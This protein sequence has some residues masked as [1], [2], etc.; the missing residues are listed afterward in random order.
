M[1][2]KRK[3]GSGRNRDVYELSNHSVLKVAKSKRGI[4]NN[5]TEVKIYK[6]TKKK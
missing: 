1:K 2:K 5:K 6:N 3:I 4:D